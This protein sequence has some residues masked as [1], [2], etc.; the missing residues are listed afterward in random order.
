MAKNIG[1][2]PE[3]AVRAAREVRV[4]FS[5]LR[6]RLR[7]SYD[8]A[9]LTPSQMSV[10][11]RLDKDGDA[12]VSDLALAE[13]VR[14]QSMASTVAVLEKRG[15]VSRRQDPDDGRRQLV[16]VRK[17]GHKLLDDGR[18]AGEEWLSRVLA[19]Q[20]TEGERQTVLKAMALLD[21]LAGS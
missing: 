7:E 1:G 17:A 13:R 6:R 16:S 21:K 5:R 20:L 8:T 15:L 9:E 10:L 14:H 11:S 12:S 2:V 3:S 4:V 18:R 19:G